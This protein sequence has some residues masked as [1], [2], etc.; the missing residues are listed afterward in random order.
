MRQKIKKTK[1]NILLKQ[2]VIVL[3]LEVIRLNNLLFPH[4]NNN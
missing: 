3:E 1:E 2:R 4:P